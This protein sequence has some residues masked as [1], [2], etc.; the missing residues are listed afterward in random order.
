MCDKLDAKNVNFMLT[1]N[2][3]PKLRKLF[4]DYNIKVVK[5][6][7]RIS[8]GKGSEYEMIITNY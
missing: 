1:T 3:H 5:K 7:S 2:K 8:Q 6:F 4:S